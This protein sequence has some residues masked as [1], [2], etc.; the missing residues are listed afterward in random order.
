MLT[1]AVAATVLVALSGI[2]ELVAESVTRT[3]REFAV[4]S[5]MTP[6]ECDAPPDEMPVVP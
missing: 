2:A 1:T 6:E 3:C 5:D 4:M